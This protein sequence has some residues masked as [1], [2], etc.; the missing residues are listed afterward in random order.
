MKILQH[1]KQSTT[2]VSYT[3]GKDDDSI[4]EDEIERNIQQIEKQEH[5]PTQKI[6]KQ[7]IQQIYHA[8]IKA[9]GHQ[10]P[11]KLS[12]KSYRSISN[13]LKTIMKTEL[14]KDIQPIQDH[15]KTYKQ[16]QT[17]EKTM[18]GITRT[19]TGYQITESL[20]MKF[21]PHLEWFNLEP[22]PKPEDT[23]LDD[24]TPILPATLDK[25]DA[26]TKYNVDVISETL[27]ASL[28]TI[29]TKQTEFLTKQTEFLTTVGN[30]KTQITN[31]N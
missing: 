21:K 8:I 3:D 19:T 13:S 6:S 10:H 4:N 22:T 27:T 30:S 17:H 9:W 14:H 16:I 29:M 12:A 2:Q 28:E 1:D 5:K 11:D 23:T 15:W 31:Q 18:R 7:D 25:P 26:I 24:P 20:Y